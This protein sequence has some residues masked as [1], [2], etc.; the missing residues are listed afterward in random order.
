MLFFDA[1]DQFRDDRAALLVGVRA[2]LAQL[3]VAY[4]LAPE[5]EREQDPVRLFLEQPGQDL[6]AGQQPLVERSGPGVAAGD[7]QHPALAA[8]GHKSGEEVLLALEVGVEG[9]FR[10][11]GL[12]GHVVHARGSIPLARKHCGRGLQQLGSRLGLALF[13]GRAPCLHQLRIPAGMRT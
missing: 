12:G 8:V 10:V 5:L 9:A 4:R 13:P 1:L 3:L 6:A 2:T 11:A 7:G